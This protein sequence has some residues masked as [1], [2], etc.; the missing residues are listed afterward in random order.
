[1]KV[2]IKDGLYMCY[3]RLSYRQVH[4]EQQSISIYLLRDAGCD[5]YI[6]YPIN[7]KLGFSEIFLK[8]ENFSLEL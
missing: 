8:K 5:E 7:H 6:I 3:Q 1:M 2:T 4:L